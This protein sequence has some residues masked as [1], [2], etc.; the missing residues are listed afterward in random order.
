ME[1]S[2]DSPELYGR[3]PMPGIVA[4]EV[5]GRTTRTWIRSGG[6]VSCREEPFRPF[7][8]L[9]NREL[10]TDCGPDV[11]WTSLHGPNPLKECASLSCLGD[12]DKALR[13]LKTR[14]GSNPTDRFAPYFAI[15]NP[16]QQALMASGRTL[17]KGLA[18]ADLVRLQID[19]E[20]R[21]AEGFDFPN[22]ERESDRILAIAL[23]DST[24][25]E[26]VLNGA[27]MEEPALIEA[28]LDLIRER[29]PDIIEGHNLFRFDLPYIRAR[30]ERY[31]I[32][33]RVGR[34]GEEADW[35]PSRFSA[36]ERTIAFTRS[37]WPGRHIMDTYFLVQLFDVSRRALGGYGL[38]EAARHFGVS[39]EHRE[40]IDAAEISRVFSRDPDRVMRYAAHDVRE[41]RALSDLL[42][43]VY[44]SQAQALPFPYQDVCLRGNAAKID[45][46]MLREYLARGEAVPRPDEPRRF[47]GGHT[48]VFETGVLRDVVHCDVQSLYPSIILKDRIAPPSDTLGAFLSM[49]RTLRDVRVR[50]KQAARAAG[51]DAERHAAES[52]Q[53]TFKILINSFY[54][55]LGFSQA[56]FGCF[57]AAERIARE[58]RALLETMMKA[59]RKKGCRLVEVDTDGIYFIPPEGAR[60]SDLRAALR[61]ALPEEIEVEF[62]GHYRAMFSYKMKNYALLEES[63][64]LVIRGAALKSRG[65]EPFQRQCTE[66][67]LRLLLEG[68]SEEIP[69]RLRETREQI[70][71][72][73]LPIRDLAK[74]ET[75]QESPDVYRAKV[76]K[77]SRARAAAYEVAL[78]SGRDYRAG[79]RVSYYV[80]GSK[81]SVTVYDNAKRVAD[82][83]PAGRDEN[84]PYYL[85]KLKSLEKKFAEWIPDP[86]QRTLGL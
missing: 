48:A 32:A 60:E 55:Y 77:N 5:D 84:V 37:H 29:D 40:L 65:L 2:S 44:F 28:M 17:F 57:D 70:R 8:W 21:T 6:A 30:A 10:L 23:S 19:I 16:E 56:R 12:L 36:A 51:S 41:T 33:L 71:N 83:D 67:L 59:L 13:R 81:K 20:T 18:F 34:G 62:D 74:T 39:E 79:D 31:G 68:R 61:E 42:S 4:V 35:R 52:M 43:P 3:D 78:R 1:F 25:W 15:R 47:A 26:T 69:A 85:E 27:E 82:W 14:T 7:L 45:A 54:G 58:G 76:E 9:E 63:G 86:N 46:L 50:A 72:R 38:K 22:A 11:E 80:T 66:A 73:T 53:S 49:L 24:G 75:L 64:D